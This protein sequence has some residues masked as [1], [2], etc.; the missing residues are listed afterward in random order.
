LDNFFSLDALKESRSS[1][2]HAS[3]ASDGIVR[4]NADTREQD[5]SLE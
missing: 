1:F 5:V 2:D 4:V 3:I